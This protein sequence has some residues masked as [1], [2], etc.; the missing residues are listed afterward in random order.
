MARLNRRIS[1]T[2]Y[3]DC[4]NHHGRWDKCMNS[5]ANELFD[6]Q[7]AELEIPQTKHSPTSEQTTHQEVPETIFE[8]IHFVE[9]VASVL[10]FSE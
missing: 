6:Y 5:T 9:S 8:T 4:R 7:S 2:K 1:W 10:T 3:Y